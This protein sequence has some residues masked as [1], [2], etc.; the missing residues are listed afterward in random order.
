MPE[1]KN[2]LSAKKPNSSYCHLGKITYQK[3]ASNGTFLLKNQ[4]VQTQPPH[5]W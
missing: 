1:G 5:G 4:Q 2:N 3:E